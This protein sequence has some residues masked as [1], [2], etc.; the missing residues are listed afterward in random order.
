MISTS[1]I[2]IS[3]V[4]ARDRVERAVQ[5]PA[6]RLRALRPGHESEEEPFRGPARAPPG[7]SSLERALQPLEHPHDAQPAVA[8]R[9]R[10]GA[11]AD[12]LDEVLALDPQRL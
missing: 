9:A 8:V 11:G 6:Q 2:K 7:P 10:R 1:P 3:C 5:A 12:A 4:I